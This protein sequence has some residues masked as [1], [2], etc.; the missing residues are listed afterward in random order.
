MTSYGLQHPEASPLAVAFFVALTIGSILI[1][2]PGLADVGLDQSGRRIW[3]GPKMRKNKA[4]VCGVE[5]TSPPGAVVARR[6]SSRE[7]YDTDSE[8]IRTNE[9]VV[10]PAGRLVRATPGRPALV[11]HSAEQRGFDRIG[12]WLIAPSNRGRVSQRQG[13]F[14]PYHE[15]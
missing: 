13:R 1:P 2:S 9:T 15:R 8:Q 12:L 14:R 6:T 3:T 10:Q 7:F 5:A 11:E 4:R